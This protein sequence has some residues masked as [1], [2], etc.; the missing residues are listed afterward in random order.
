MLL[1]DLLEARRNPEMNPKVKSGL[2]KYL[3]GHYYVT[4][5]DIPKVGVNPRLS[6]TTPYGIYAYPLFSPLSESWV[7]QG[8][9][10]AGH[11]EYANV[12][13]N[14]GNELMLSSVDNHHV[15][16]VNEL[17]ASEFG[18]EIVDIAMSDFRSRD[19]AKT[20][21]GM[22]NYLAGARTLGKQNVSAQK[23]Y[24]MIREI[25]WKLIV[26]WNA[27]LRELGWD[28]IT[29]D[30]GNVIHN[31]EKFQTVF[32]NPRAI[33]LVERFRNPLKPTNKQIKT[34]QHLAQL[35]DTTGINP[36][37]LFLNTMELRYT[38]L[39]G[40]NYNVVMTPANGRVLGQ[41][42]KIEVGDFRPFTIISDKEK[43][44]FRA[45]VTNAFSVEER[46]ELA[47]IIRAKVSDSDL[48]NLLGFD[49]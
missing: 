4:F 39:N 31:L 9:P 15:E 23:F 44:F 30:V 35:L 16:R 27:L 20:F 36:Y 3:E 28:T 38:T 22:T 48:S 1:T 5:T 19:P 7:R 12:L 25:A 45:F 21:W 47:E 8:F 46:Q 26:K 42:S 34:P 37:Y 2:E 18:Q 14:R 11:R 6:W 41:R 29:D 13:S 32:L 33:T 49:D 10:F 24:M 40:I 43:E 17:F